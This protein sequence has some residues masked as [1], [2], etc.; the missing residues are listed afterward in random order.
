MYIGE[1]NMFNI[2]DYWPKNTTRAVALW[3]PGPDNTLVAVPGAGGGQK[4]VLAMNTVGTF[5][6]KSATSRYCSIV[7]INQ[8]YWVISAEC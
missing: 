6:Y 1:Y 5:G 4:V 3:K 8:T 7:E 2:D